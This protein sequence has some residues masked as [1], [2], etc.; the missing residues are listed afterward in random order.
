MP[1]AKEVTA[2]R[3][4]VHGFISG[5]QVGK[6]SKKSKLTRTLDRIRGVVKATVTNYRIGAHAGN[7]GQSR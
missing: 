4:P 3:C 6:S 7:I 1:A 5:S 2:Q